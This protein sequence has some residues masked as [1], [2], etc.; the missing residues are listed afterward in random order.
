MDLVF[1][2]EAIEPAK[3]Y[4][5]WRDA[6]CD[7]YVHVDVKATD[8]ENYKG[9]IRE[10]E[11][12]D[13]VLTDILLSEQ[14]INRNPQH[15][16]KLDKDCYYIQLLHSGNLNVLQH[17]ET[18]ASNAARGA[19]FCATEQYELQCIGDVRSFYLEIPR[20]KFAER[21]PKD[22][23][24][25]CAPI[26]CTRGLGRV[27]TEFCA[28]LAAED[29]N[30]GDSTRAELGDQLLDILALTLLSK[31][32][33]LLLSE[34]SVQKA[35]LRSVQRWIE[36]HLGDPNLTLEKIAQA[37]N[38]S[39]R[40]LHLLFSQID[41]SV[42]N[43]LWDRRLQRCYG[44]IASGDSRS[45]TAIAFDHGFS[46]SAHFSTMFRRKYGFR[47]SDLRRSQ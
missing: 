42:S 30:I 15:I 38:M 24:P 26:D 28:S 27:A 45:I 10:T 1:S 25:L 40:Y 36:E 29:P 17:G 8:P 6:I 14:R 18:H 47:P 37:N 2:T 11:F 31:E 46:S 32:S 3:R 9:F 22:S 41:M 16:A 34:C 44:A 35:R 13:V 4:S 21:F 39:L 23:K 12:G 7:V 19:L 20:D 33:D 5:A 43:W